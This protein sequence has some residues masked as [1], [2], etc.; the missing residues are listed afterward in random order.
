MTV[1]EL[2]AIRTLL[3]EFLNVFNG[4]IAYYEGHSCFWLHI[5]AVQLGRL[6]SD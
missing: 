3:A 4:L 1:F 2:H 6:E 5:P